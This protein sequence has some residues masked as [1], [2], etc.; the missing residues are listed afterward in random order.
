MSQ[1][2]AILNLEAELERELEGGIVSYEPDTWVVVIKLN[3]NPFYRFKVNEG[4]AYRVQYK[5]ESVA[6]LVAQ[7]L[8]ERT[9]QPA[10]G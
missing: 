1:E 9:Q 7:H 6:D 8:F 4:D 2:R 3:G 5:S 10:E